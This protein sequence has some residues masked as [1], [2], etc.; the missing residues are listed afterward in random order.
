[1]KWY[2]YLMCF[3]G[4][5]FVANFV[6]HFVEGITGQAF[7]SPFADPPGQ[8]LSPPGLNVVWGLSNLVVGYLLLRYGNFSLRG[9]WA[10]VIVTFAGFAL[11][12]FM[13]SG[14]FEP[15]GPR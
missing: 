8:G 3:F 14:A 5:A 11:F 10:A 12:A 6:P 9:P 2:H 1:M 15:I 4:G 13:L 7:P